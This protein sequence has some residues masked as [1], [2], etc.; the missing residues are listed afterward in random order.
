V[1]RFTPGPATWTRGVMG[2]WLRGDW[3]VRQAPSFRNPLFWLYH[4]GARYSPTGRFADSVNFPTA[5]AARAF[6][7]AYDK[8]RSR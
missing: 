8:E 7:D 5:K 4:F 2:D 3:R 6:A 1:S